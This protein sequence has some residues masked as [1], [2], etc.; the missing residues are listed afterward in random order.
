MSTTDI[1]HPF[2]RDAHAR[3]ALPGAW[4]WG[5][6]L[7]TLSITLGL[8][9]WMVWAPEQALPVFWGLVVPAVP[10]VLVLAPGLWRQVCPMALMNQLP[11]TLRIGWRRTLPDG[12]QRASFGI[13]MGLFIL[14]VALRGPV[15]NTHGPLLAGVLLMMGA[16][17]FAGGLVFKGR[18]GWC[19]TFCPLGPVQRAYGHAP[20]AVV[21]NGYCPSC[22]GCQQHCFDANPRQAIFQDLSADDPRHAQWRQWFFGLLP[23]LI[24][25]FFTLS[26]SVAASV[27]H[28]EARLL[29]SALASLGLYAL[30]STALPIG[31]YR[32]SLLFGLT[33]LALFYLYTGPGMVR[34]AAAL[35]G[36]E[37]SPHAQGWATGLG[38]LGGLSML[39]NGLRNE[40]L[41]RRTLR[42]QRKAEAQRKA[43]WQ[44]IHL[45]RPTLRN[46]ATGQQS[47]VEPGQRLAEALREQGTRLPKGC[48]AG[49]CGGDAVAICE[50]LEQ[51]PP[52]GAQE[53]ATLRRLGLEGRARLACMCEVTAP[54]A[55]DTR[56]EALACAPDGARAS[57]PDA[58]QQQGIEQVVIIGNGIAGVSMAEALRR[59][60]PGVTL[61]LVSDEAHPF[62]NRMGLADALGAS[63]QVSDLYLRDAAWADD[64]RITPWLRAPVRRI[65]RHTQ[66]VVFKD[67]RTLPY[68]RLVLATG[69]HA[70][71]P[72]AVFDA[73][74]NAFVLRTIAD[75]ERIQRHLGQHDARRATV[76]GGGVLGVEA[77][78][79]LQ[80][81]GLQVH[82]LERA[83]HLMAAQLDAVGG[84]HLTDALVARGI[85]VHTQ[86]T[87]L[88]W[89]TDAHQQLRG[90]RMGDGPELATDIVVACLGIRPRSRLAQEAGLRVQA[91]GIEVDGLQRTSDPHILAV[92]DVALTPGPGGLWATAVAQAERAVQ[93]LLAQEATG[94]AGPLMLKLKADDLDVVAW[95]DSRAQDSDE[96]WQADADSG[97]FWRVVW[98]ADS[99]AGWQCVGPAGS[100]Q[101]LAQAL[102]S[103][104]PRQARD[105]LDTL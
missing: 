103:G 8:I 11:R 63:A 28:Y 52:P 68:D 74:G 77:A 48:G 9:T 90:V 66:T 87:A 38:L 105:A 24:V 57:G 17:A 76:V 101:A 3:S 42:A 75:V 98:R 33:A 49:I 40:H 39:V 30:L 84:A 69:A 97:F 92:G 70:A 36:L 80:L 15:L 31:R 65:D 6:R 56:R 94:D 16:L 26:P 79:A 104:C 23:G 46:V 91:R 7:F 1:V 43:Q 93:G 83:P 27:W 12:W 19:G 34:Q 96:V 100:A 85:S 99:L 2:A 82:L 41:H 35:L 95:G 53:L 32:L 13:A 20:L 64:W 59:H 47:T 89:V 50:G 88:H 14:G 21:P 102:H 72:D 71:R 58:L 22:V 67:G 62:Y 4:W 29:G 54:I 10:M 86:V 51:L 44:A 45:H 5:L 78:L 37:A 25:G 18:S 60:C 81:R 73:A 61:H 55:V